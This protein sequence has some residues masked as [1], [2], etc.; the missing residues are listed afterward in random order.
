MIRTQIFDSV[1]GRFGSPVRAALLV[2]PFDS[3]QVFDHVSKAFYCASRDRSIGLMAAIALPRNETHVKCVGK[4]L[5]VLKTLEIE[6]FWTLSDGSVEVESV[7][8]CWDQT[9]KSSKGV[10]HDSKKLQPNYDYD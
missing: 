1:S 2:K 4:I 9:K 3:K 6:V 5:P 8:H 10:K 7:W